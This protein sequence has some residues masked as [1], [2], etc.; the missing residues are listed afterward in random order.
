MSTMSDWKFIMQLS[1]QADT[2][3]HSIYAQLIILITKGFE[4]YGRS[5][6][7]FGLTLKYLTIPRQFYS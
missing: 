6:W 2:C 1:W 5:C 7:R 4:Y 3:D